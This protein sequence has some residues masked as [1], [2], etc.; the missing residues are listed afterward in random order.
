MMQPTPTTRSARDAPVDP[1]FDALGGRADELARRRV[2]P[3]VVVHGISDGH[4]RAGLGL[5]LRAGHEAVASQ[6]EEELNRGVTHACGVQLLEDRRE[7]EVDGSRP[8]HVVHDERWD[9]GVRKRVIR[10]AAPFFPLPGK[11]SRV[12]AAVNR[13]A[14]SPASSVHTRR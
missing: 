5:D 12:I 1:D 2:L 6:G 10:A 7:D 14:W 8:A 4:R 11:V 3:V 13:H 9:I